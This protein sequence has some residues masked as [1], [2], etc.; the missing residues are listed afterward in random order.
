[1]KVSLLSAA[2]ML[3]TPT[4][5]VAAQKCGDLSVQGDMN[6]CFARA[7]AK[8]DSELNS[9]YKQIEARLKGA[10]DTKK[11]LVSTQKA[12]VVFR[13]AECAFSSFESSG[14]S[15][16]PA[17][18]NGCLDSMTKVRIEAFKGYLKCTDADTDC[19]VPAGD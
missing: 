7:Y 2:L 6:E 11:L 8:S 14:G 17:I 4:F 3:A 1:M 10:D 9:L 5:A 12:W 18:Y 16:Y 19:P 13:D 15:M